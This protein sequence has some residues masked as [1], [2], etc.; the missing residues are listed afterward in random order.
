MRH[1][2]E[3]RKKDSL[4]T[5]ANQVVLGSGKRQLR[6]GTLSEHQSERLFVRFDS[7]LLLDGK[8]LSVMGAGGHELRLQTLRQPF[9]RISDIRPL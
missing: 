9:L 5:P 6:I 7:H 4:P 8:P 1:H 3:E 2:L